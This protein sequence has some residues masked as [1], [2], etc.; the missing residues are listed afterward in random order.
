MLLV[1]GC[2]SLLR[3]N[4]PTE[5]V[6]VCDLAQHD[7]TSFFFALQHQQCFIIIANL[8]PEQL[9]SLKQVFS[10]RSR[11]VHW[12]STRPFEKLLPSQLLPRLVH[13]FG[14]AIRVEHENIGWLQSYNR[15]T[16][17]GPRN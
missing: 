1:F 13:S 2:L 12:S 15:L 3:P 6:V 5:R 10:Q 7:K 9:Q 4:Q 16:V 14:N 11:R 8:T 17:L